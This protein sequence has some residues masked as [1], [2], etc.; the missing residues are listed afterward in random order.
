MTPVISAAGLLV[1][2]QLIFKGK[3]E[4]CEPS[5]KYQ[6]AFFKRRDQEAPDLLFDFNHTEN[7]WCS[8]VANVREGLGMD[9]G[10]TEGGVYQ[11]N[12]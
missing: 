8:G 6:Q 1:A 4:A 7:H 5:A 9:G 3:T 10:V 11:V 12:K 2:I